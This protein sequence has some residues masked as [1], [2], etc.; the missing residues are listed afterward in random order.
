MEGY[1]LSRTFNRFLRSASLS[2]KAGVQ[3]DSAR[4]AERRCRKRASGSAR[5]IESSAEVVI[6]IKGVRDLN[7]GPTRTRTWDKRIMSPLL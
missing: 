4:I 1:C 6:V 2:A 5:D 3:K 7:G